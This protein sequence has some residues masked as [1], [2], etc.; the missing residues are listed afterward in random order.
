MRQIFKVF[1]DDAERMRGLPGIEILEIDEATS[2]IIEDRMYEKKDS[3]F[4]R[5]FNFI[6]RIL[7]GDEQL[8]KQYPKY[9]RFDPRWALVNFKMLFV[10]KN[11]F[12]QMRLMV[13]VVISC[14]VALIIFVA[15]VWL[16]TTYDLRDRKPIPKPPVFSEKFLKEHAATAKKFNKR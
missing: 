8:R 13:L 4:K 11:I 9:G 14:V 3:F 12:F 6:N 7:S 10:K 5:V 1:K 16:K 15:F 2:L